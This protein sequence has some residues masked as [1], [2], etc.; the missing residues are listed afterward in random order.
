MKT[1]QSLILILLT[2]PLFVS[3]CSRPQM[4]TISIEQLRD[5]I[6]GGWAAKMIG[7]SY[8]CPSEF[9]ALGQTYEKKLAWEPGHVDNSLI[10]DDL[11]VQ[12]SF[13]MAMDD[14]G[15]DAPVEKF[16]EYM[17]NAKFGLAHANFQARK[18][19]WDGIMPPASG[20]PE[21]NLHAD[22]IDFQIDADYIGFMC[23]GM[24]RTSNRIADKI[25][26][27]MNYG[28]GVYGGMFVA[29]LHTQA[30][31][32]K[33]IPSI[34]DRALLAIP[35][36]SDYAKCIKDVIRLHRKYPDEWRA[37]WVELE[38]RWSPV[39]ICIRGALSPYNIDAKINGAYI[40]MGLLYGEGDF[41]RTLDISLRC[42]QDS[43]CNPSNAA[44]VLGILNGYSRIPDEWKSGI[45]A[46]SDAPF[47]YTTYTFNSAVERTIEYAGQLV[48]ENGGIVTEKDMTVKLQ[49]P[50]AP[51]L[52]VSFPN[53]APAYRSDV[54]DG[55]GWERSEGWTVFSEGNY[56]QHGKT[57]EIG[58]TSEKQGAEARF[59]FEGTGVA[60]A[61]PY[62]VRGGKADIFLDGNFLRTIDTYHRRA[63]QNHYP[64]WH[65]LNLEPGPHTVR[66]VV[67][68]DKRPASQGTEVSLTGATVYTT[69]KK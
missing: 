19:F 63:R 44:A 18:N 14:F 32:E 42:G 21:N 2:I 51:E 67:R 38:R 17:A 1:R 30:F 5:K 35:S 49:I 55:T 53:T 9:V 68:G 23:P 65:I 6:A 64:I 31:F 22:D 12:L 29:A 4:R 52:E 28:D 16:A 61:G 43:D 33:D 47:I 8:G 59:A 48:K 13:M 36:Q 10:Q 26:H 58:I 50:V 11:F 60:L 56:Y 46:I 27:I 45:P 41:T 69:L 3:H 40:V 25:G 54:L 37:A 15:I 24:P 34:V 66:L 62:A 7:V 20:A 39:D 57:M